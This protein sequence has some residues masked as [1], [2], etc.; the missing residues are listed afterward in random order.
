VAGPA[1]AAWAAAAARQDHGDIMGMFRFLDHLFT[2]RWHMRRAFGEADLTRIAEAVGNS[3]KYHT[4]QIVVALEAS[5]PLELLL[6]GMTPRQRA[7]QTFKLLN[8]W[9][10]EANNGVLLYLCLADRDV[11]II[12][13]RG[14]HSHVG[15]QAWESICREME[16]MLKARVTSD[17]IVTAVQRIGALLE[18]FHPR[19]D[20][21]QADNM[22]PDKPVIL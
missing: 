4:G 16:T 7:E 12:A 5:L 3:E 15:T 14:I 8:V 22:L 9:D 11:E 18:Q 13:D 2:T 21:Q 19:S 10:T 17:P 6:D 1:A 20:G